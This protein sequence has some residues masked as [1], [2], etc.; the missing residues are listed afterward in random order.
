M[1]ERTGEFKIHECLSIITQV[2]KHSITQTPTQGITHPRLIASVRHHL[3]P[4]YSITQDITDPK[5]CSQL[6]LTHDITH[7]L[8]H[9]VTQT[10]TRAPSLYHH[11]FPIHAITQTPL[12]SS[13]THHID[14]QLTTSYWISTHTKNGLEITRN[15]FSMLKIP[16]E[17]KF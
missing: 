15:S 3:D 5:L 17:N 13:F 8:V 9:A 12:M 6:I 2:S 1:Q 11:S 14:S 4:V 10:P 7:S 16:A